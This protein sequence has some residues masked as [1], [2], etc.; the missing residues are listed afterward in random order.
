MNNS[1]IKFVDFLFLEKD[2]KEE[3]NKGKGVK[4]VDEKR[5]G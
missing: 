5:R 4:Q 3:G 2:I 1:F